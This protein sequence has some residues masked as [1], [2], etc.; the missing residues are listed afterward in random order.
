MMKTPLSVLRILQGIVLFVPFVAYAQLAS[1][2][3][4]TSTSSNENNPL[5]PDVVATKPAAEG[6]DPVFTLSPFI[7]TAERDNGYQATQTLAGT[8]LNTPVKDLGAS[9]SIYTKDF[10]EDIGATNAGELLVFATGME[11]AGAGGNY[12]AAAA[13]ANATQVEGNTAR[14]NSQ[15]S[16]TRGL[17]SPNF[18]RNFFT[19][20]IPFDTYNTESVTV[21]RGP[22]AIL[23]GVGSPAG[24]VENTLLLPYFSRNAN[25]IEMRY[26]NNDSTRA[27]I[28]FNRVL[29]K[30][31]LAF[32]IAALNQDERYNQRPAFEER[33]RLYGALAFQ[34]FKATIL[35][36]NFET[37]NTS[38]NRP[39]TVLPYNSISQGWYDAGRPSWDWS[40][41]DD[42]A[43]NPGAAA[44]NSNAYRTPFIGQQQIY[45]Q[46]VSVFPTANA[47][48]PA[49][50]FAATTPITF[51]T[52]A[53]A[54]RAGTFNSLVN[55]DKANDSIFFAQTVNIFSLP[56]S[57]WTGANVLPGQQSGFAPAGIK[58]QGFTNYDAFD[59]K[60]RMLDETSRQDDSFHSFNLAL[61]QRAWQDRV[62]IEIAY[63]T[64][65]YE[66][67]AKNSFFS[68][69]NG[70]HIHID[71][72]VTLPT[73]EPNPNLGRPFVTYGQNPW[74]NYATDRET[75]RATG[76]LRYDFKDLSK[77]WGSWLGRHTLTGLY[78]EN[79]VETIS[80]QTAL[81]TDGPAARALNPN[82]SVFTR[83]PAV[84]VYIGP[85]NIGSNNGL[86][87]DPIQ[88]PAIRPGPAGST[89]Y[90]V[91]AAGTADPGSFADSDLSF[92]DINRGGTLSRQ[93][94]KSQAAVLQSYWLQDHLITIAGWRRDEA[95]YASRNL[96][97]T[98]NPSDPGDPGKVHWGFDDLSFPH[99]PPRLAAKETKSYSAV[100]RWPQKLIKLPRGTDI[101]LF[102]NKSEN[103]TPLGGRV[104]TYGNE[105]APP[106]GNTKEFGVNLF[107]FN[108][109]FNVRINR[110]ETSVTGQTSTS[111]AYVVATQNAVVQQASLWATEGNR[112]P[113]NVAL[114]DAAI[115]K[116]FSPL[117]ANYASLYQYS[118]NGVA[119]N[120]STTLVGLP[121]KSD[122]VDYTAKGTEVDFI[123]NPTRNWRILA[124]VSKQETVQ[125]NS[126]PN[127]K[128]FFERMLPAWNDS[129]NGVR[130]RDIPRNGYPSGTGPSNP[131]ANVQSFGEWLDAIVL[132]PYATQ[133][134][135]DGS[136]SAE[137]RKWRAN[138]VF[139]YTFGHGSF[140][141]DKL[142]GWNIGGSVR[143]Q[144]KLGIGY[145]TTRN[146]D[147]TVN[148]D[149]QH[150]YYA[151]AETNVD[152]RI[153]YT[154][155][156]WKK[157][158]DWKVQLNV[159]NLI[160]N[161]EPIAI[162][163]QPWGEYST[164]R[165]APERRW[166]LTNT[167]TF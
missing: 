76:Y 128:E 78:E 115:A 121:G 93:V 84:I 72:N 29:I 139:N 97:F 166:Y 21:N 5:P 10:L 111:A 162:G 47:T 96:G 147:G 160:A 66:R 100:L 95:Y 53:N 27:I 77:T 165:I 52:A 74:N 39:I 19:T 25:K 69:S 140:L 43:R 108:D 26:G 145:P 62:G 103:F 136:A 14:E 44:Q 86:Q 127:F 36:A 106:Q 50:S 104:D 31:K 2:A 35:R 101:S 82:M 20:D 51:G 158:I 118:V 110:F 132:V 152:A 7:V 144:D 13:D 119:P 70:N 161:D 18:T 117:P 80:Y 57:Y 1:P 68:Y 149:I 156:I 65:R 120:I 105:M 92:V 135:T 167:F 32:R 22:N 37:G 6:A 15:Q 107:A 9:I 153:G 124:N 109:K 142:K 28:D 41:Y 133:L 54:V 59:F 151:P 64:Q 38:A 126:F 113:D 157:R 55:R 134:A 88:I 4:V 46:I 122:T 71:P 75:W 48:T 98:P 102:Y 45:T 163:V 130:L 81:A 63:D 123:F 141:G 85:S 11:V 73:G 164:V 154:R 146:A 137:Q 83:R 23:F 12:S 150:P 67:S 87:L 42:P 129:V 138:C 79:A 58:M 3:N 114:M 17:A 30:N 91:R 89:K 148:V 143:W 112:N 131:P 49:Y 56:G 61:E 24:V 90:F 34:P 16:R 159:V 33:K 40:Y 94:I 8:R 116:L 125:T 155:K 99:L 60:N